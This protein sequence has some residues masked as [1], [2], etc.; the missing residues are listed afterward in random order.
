MYMYIYIVPFYMS[1]ISK[2]PFTYVYCKTHFLHISLQQN[3]LSPKCSNKASFNMTDF[4]NKPR[5]S[6]SKYYKATKENEIRKASGK[7]MELKQDL[8]KNLARQSGM[9]SLTRG[10]WL[11]SFHLSNF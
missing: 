4:P 9:F 8:I 1:V 11:Q 6:A 7:R 3:L 5:A 2:P 10:S